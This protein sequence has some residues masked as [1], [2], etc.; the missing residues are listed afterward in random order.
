MR[1][2]QGCPTAEA[3]RYPRVASGNTLASISAL[4][5]TLTGAAESSVALKSGMAISS[6]RR[7]LV[8]KVPLGLLGCAQWQPAP[9]RLLAG[10]ARQHRLADQ[11]VGVAQELDHFFAAE[12]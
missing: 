12:V 9:D 4:S 1:R 2:A 5:A 10:I 3:P 8:V 7:R 6:E 11:V